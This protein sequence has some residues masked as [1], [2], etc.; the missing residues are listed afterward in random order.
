MI[1]LQFRTPSMFTAEPRPPA[2]LSAQQLAELVQDFF[3]KTQRELLHVRSKMRSTKTIRGMFSR[4][5]LPPSY[6]KAAPNWVWSLMIST[7]GSRLAST[8]ATW[9]VNRI[10]NSNTFRI[11]E[12]DSATNQESIAISHGAARRWPAIDRPRSPTL[13]DH[14]KSMANHSRD[15]PDPAQSSSRCSGS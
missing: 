3:R 12:T 6:S 10:C 11:S 4:S 14:P 8:G 15:P 13:A 7:R 9:P 2:L 1:K 5:E